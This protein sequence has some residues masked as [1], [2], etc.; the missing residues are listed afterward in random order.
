MKSVIWVRER[1]ERAQTAEQMN[2]IWLD[3]VGKTSYFC[4]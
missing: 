3:K 4:D 2:F 1:Y